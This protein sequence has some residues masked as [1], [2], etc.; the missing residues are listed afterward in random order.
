MCAPCHAELMRPC[1][2]GAC[3]ARCA[4]RLN[5]L[6]TCPDCAGRVLA[7]DYAIAALAYAPVA[8]ALILQLKQALRWG[9][10]G[11]LGGLLADAVRADARG[12]PPRAVLVPV[13][14]SASALRRRGFNPAAEIAREV[15]RRLAVPVR[16]DILVSAAGTEVRQSSL[17]RAQRRARDAGRF[18]L[19]GSVTDVAVPVLLVDDVMTTGST[20]HA[21]ATILRQACAGPIV[22]LAV[23]RTPH[24]P[25]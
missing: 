23:A 12:L 21:A 8:D 20:L 4:L 25:S 6:A 5:G 3:C 16:H 11:M 14:S 22:A 19:H 1:A 9:R 13:P 24:L 17:S 15:G 18:R 2:P 7:F 10:A